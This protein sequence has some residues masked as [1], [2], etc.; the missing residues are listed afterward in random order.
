MPRRSTADANL[1]RIVATVILRWRANTISFLGGIAPSLTA[2]IGK[3]LKA[4][5]RSSS[6]YFAVRESLPGAFRTRVKTIESTGA[7]GQADQSWAWLN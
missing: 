1:H 3:M 5:M 2:T 4:M 7:G 6:L